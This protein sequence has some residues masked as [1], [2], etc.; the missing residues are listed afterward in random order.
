[1]AEQDN[2]PVWT[3]KPGRYEV[4]FLTMSDGNRGFWIRYTLHAPDGGSP[5][6]RLWFAAFDR[7]QPDNTFGINRGMQALTLQGGHTFEVKVGDAFLRSGHASGSLSGAG[8]DVSWEIHFPTGDPT[9]RLLPPA[10]YRGK[11]APT[12]P[13]APN[14]DTRFSGRITIDAEDVMLDG[15]PGQQGHLYGIKHA[16]RWAWAHCSSFDGEDAVLHALTAQGRR[17]PINTPFSTFVGLRWRGE[18]LRFRKVSRHRDYW[19]GGWRLDLAN[20][21]Y[22]L[23]GRVA[24]DPA[25]LVRARYDDPD[26][27]PRFCH[28]GEVCS[29][30]FVLF[31][32]RRGGFEEVTVLSSEGTTHAE[33]AGRTPGPSVKRE[34]VPLDAAGSEAGGALTA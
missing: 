31:E 1:M 21:R 29:S 16:E 11:M 13:F 8:H 32:R 2:L 9:F 30:R 14:I 5:G 6:A 3:G 7:D 20:R 25:L 4:W 15:M 10:L 23:T 24:G 22:R 19:L 28:N 33:W 27:T 26:G 34:H 12:K 18:W 17:G